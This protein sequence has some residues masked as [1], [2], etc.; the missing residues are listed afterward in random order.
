MQD[1]FNFYGKDCYQ[2]IQQCSKDYPQPPPPPGA[3]T[4]I[5]PSKYDVS[6]GWWRAGRA[7]RPPLDAHVPSRSPRPFPLT[8]P[9][10]CNDWYRAQGLDVTALTPSSPSASP[11]MSPA[12]AP[13]MMASPPMVMASPPMDMASPPME[14][15]SPPM[16]MASPPMDM[17]SPPMDM[18]SPPAAEPT[19]TPATSAP[20]PAPSSAARLGGVPSALLFTAAALLAALVA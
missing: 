14:M 2:G 8:T 17:A 5:D 15:M 7:Q 10:N 16:V 4:T 19:T 3:G 6:W 1:L 11:T 18:A 12:P 13:E 9:Q 20:A